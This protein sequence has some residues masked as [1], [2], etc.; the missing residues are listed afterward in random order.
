MFKII[1]FVSDKNLYDQ[2]ILNT[3]VLVPN[4]NAVHDCHNVGATITLILVL[5]RSDCHWSVSV[6]TTNCLTHIQAV[7][8][9]RWPLNCQ[10]QNYTQHR[11]F[12][13]ER[14]VF[15]HHTLTFNSHC[16]RIRMCMVTMHVCIHVC[17][18]ASHLATGKHK[19]VLHSTYLP[20]NTI[21]S[22]PWFVPSV[23]PLL[24]LSVP[25]VTPTHR[26]TDTHVHTRTHTHRHIHTH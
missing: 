11:T 16:M 15:V 4:S 5:G 21:S 18:C 12:N 24:S 20:L 23:R 7:G 6:L 8:R 2:N 13:R 14:K 10:T 1:D 26:H 22:V 3:Y 9:W 17:L 19:Q 25:S